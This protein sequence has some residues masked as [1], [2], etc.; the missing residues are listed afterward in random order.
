MKLW[1]LTDAQIEA[2]EKSGEV[3]F[4][5]NVLSPISGTVT[6]RHIA[7]GDYV[8]EG[9]ALFEVV[10]L[11]HVWVMFDAYESDI[12][13]IKL[14]DK[15]KFKIK[16]LP[17]ELFESTVTFID[18]V[19]NPMSRVA[20][21]RAELENS[22]DLLKPEML[23][24]G[25]LRTM[26][27]GADDQ[28]VVPKSAILWTGKKAV[29]YVMTDD[30][31]NMFQYREINLGADAGAYYLVESGLEEGEMIATNGV[32]KIDAAAQLKGEKSM[33][34]PEGGKVSMG[35][36]HGEKPKRN[37]KVND[38]HKNHQEG[39]SESKMNMQID[40]TF[41]LQLTNAYEIQLNL[42]QAFIAS[43]AHSVKSNS[44]LVKE[45]FKKIDMNL[46][47]GEMHTKWIEVFKEI[48]QSLNMMN[49]ADDIG[50]QRQSYAHYNDAL[51]SAIKMYGLRD[52]SVYVNYCPMA[53]DGEGAYWLSSSKEIENPYFGESMLSCGET[54]ELIN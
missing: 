42:L 37:S 52:K 54:K 13:W 33:M 24:D 2:I 40:E 8:K 31:N 23:T 14:K 49:A 45:S 27:P 6:M 21:V 46:L 36:N 26:L 25:I 11:S 17:G 19:I 9:S 51:Y 50:R 34:N 10:D 18:P 43:D 41:Q 28:L 44:E 39:E 47:S 5:F 20:K 7:L 3:N 35:H 16:S 22:K 29:V 48:D 38:E 15:I 30:H 53:R 4:Y 1:D 12:P 32:F